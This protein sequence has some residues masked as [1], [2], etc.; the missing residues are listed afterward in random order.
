MLREDRGPPRPARRG[1]SENGRRPRGRRE[2]RG[3][4]RPAPHAVLLAFGAE[5]SDRIS[6]PVAHR[7]SIG[8][9]GRARRGRDRQRGR[10]SRR[11]RSGDRRRPHGHG[12]QGRQG[13]V[14]EQEEGG[15]PARQGEVRHLRRGGRL[16]RQRRRAPGWPPGGAQP[17]APGSLVR[18]LHPATCPRPAQRGAATSFRADQ[19]VLFA[20]TPLLTALGAYSSLHTR[21][22]CVVFAY[23]RY[24][25]TPCLRSN[26]SS[27]QCDVDTRVVC[28]AFPRVSQGNLDRIAPRP[29]LALCRVQA[30]HSGGM[31]SLSKT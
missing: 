8:N 30:P 10:G 31:R 29:G 17:P 26:C 18:E 16:G 13:R 20:R 19:E 14:Q 23:T 1:A 27:L 7:L 3:P 11:A 24:L 22:S 6:A 12:R 21:C 4:P 15:I 9:A 5:A 2:A 28:V 25:L